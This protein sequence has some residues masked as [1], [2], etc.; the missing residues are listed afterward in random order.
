MVVKVNRGSGSSKLSAYKQAIHRSKAVHAR[1]NHDNINMWGNSITHLGYAV[2]RR[3]AV[4]KDTPAVSK[5]GG[6]MFG[7]L[8][9][10]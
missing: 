7:E 9:M 8:E 10:N 3:D 6:E 5:H 2:N 1:I 4:H